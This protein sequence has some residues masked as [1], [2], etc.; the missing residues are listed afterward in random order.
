V[1]FNRGEVYTLGTV[2][3][4]QDAEFNRSTSDLNARFIVLKVSA[5]K[6]LY[7]MSRISA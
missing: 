5:S 7:L 2:Y 3:V 1:V 6:R 4:F